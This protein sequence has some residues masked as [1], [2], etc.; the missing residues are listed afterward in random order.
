MATAD[1]N[2]RH[3]E[4]MAARCRELRGRLDDCL[5]TYR[6]RQISLAERFGIAGI[7]PRSYT[8]ATRTTILKQAG[9][10]REPWDFAW[11][12][13]TT[14]EPKQI[15][16]PAS[17]LQSLA[18]HLVDQVFL[19]ADDDGVSSPR[20]CFLNT[21]AADL[22]LSALVARARPSSPAAQEILGDYFAFRQ[23][24][25]TLAPRYSPLALCWSL[26]WSLR[27]TVL[28]TVNPSSLCMLLRN[29]C[30]L[31]TH[32]RA[33][34]QQVFADQDWQAAFAARGLA[35]RRDEVLDW[36]A[37]TEV[38]PKP[39]RMLPD[40]ELIS[41]WQ[42]GYVRPFVDQL[43]QQLVPVQSHQLRLAPLFSL[44]TEVVATSIY[45]H[46]SREAG[47][48]IDPDCCYEFLP[49]DDEATPDNVLRPWELVKGEEYRM[50]VSDAYGLVRYDTQDVF[51]CVGHVH[52]TP[53]IDFVRRHGLNYSFTG[54]KLTDCHLQ[55]AFAEVAPVHGL[56]G[57]AWTCFPCRGSRSVP[58][59]VFVVLAAEG[60]TNQEQAAAQLDAALCRI[61]AEYASKRITD[62]LAAPVLM[63]MPGEAFMATLAR[64]LPRIAAANPAQFKL[65][66][67]YNVLWED[68]LAAAKESP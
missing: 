35:A 38:P 32:L 9:Q 44:S 10:C 33:Q 31:W 17:R 63:T 49:R 53:L 28:M 19:A 64:A 24:A 61:N 59:Y 39:A 65:L 11:T 22:S 18:D 43:R 27:P 5:A 23:A 55:A 40:V 51:R 48:P 36:L 68:V 2:A 34:V 52:D 14:N 15:F 66:P 47:L 1:R 45:P 67:L 50:V 62:R 42:G 25:M 7:I 41:C 37:A 46:L 57:A 12:S 8:E 6:T 4:L 21:F 26:I 54:E 58:G 60:Q 30:G 13:G 56:S 3:R 16:Y 20:F 29:G